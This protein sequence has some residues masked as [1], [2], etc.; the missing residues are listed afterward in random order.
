MDKESKEPFDFLK[1]DKPP[2]EQHIAVEQKIIHLM[3][4]HRD[5]VEEMIDAGYSADFFSSSHHRL[6]EAIYDEFLT[7]NGKRVLTRNSYKQILLKSGIK[8][9]IFTYLT[10]FDKCFLQAYAT[11]DDLGQLKI[12][13]RES[14]IARKV[15]TCLQSF[16]KDIKKTGWYS[17][18]CG[19]V[20]GMQD[21]LSMVETRRAVFASVNDMQSEYI[22]NLEFTR[23]N[24]GTIVKCGIEEIDN[25]VNVGF[26][27]QHLTLFVADVASHKTNLMLNVGM[28]LADREHNVLFIPLEM[29]R[30]DLLNRMVAR[31]CKIHFSRL[32]RPDCLSETELKEIKEAKMWA[33]KHFYILDAD[34]RTSVSKLKR[35]I[36]KHA[37]VFKP[38]V[39]IID[40]IANLE[41]DVRFGGRN[42]LEIGEIL[43]SLRF[44]GK[45]YGFHIISAAQMGRSAIRTLKEKGLDNSNAAPDS[46]SIRGSHEYS[47][48]ADTIF[49][50]MKVPDE[51]DKLKIYTLKARSG[52]SGHMQTLHVQPEFCF[53]EGESATYNLAK[54]TDVDNLLMEPPNI[55]DP[56]APVA[57]PVLKIADPFDSV[58]NLDLDDQNKEEDPWASM[59]L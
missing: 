13:F 56:A 9:D 4:Q 11:Y 53:I 59:G 33:N 18:A 20:D 36:E 26:K 38:A 45:K 27:P 32:A 22:Q 46:T 49:T 15:D 58:T 39:V 43:K 25:A 12:A 52:P 41:P 10:V 14:Y 34:E 3:L 47:A 37:F 2:V 7:S 8:G 19:L 28:N 31:K 50:L 51:D 55:I 5:V 24:P 42:D 48:D 21:T 23:A 57:P 17:A 29:N 44:L 6:I 16:V 30:L 54:A 35:E 40:Y 1:A